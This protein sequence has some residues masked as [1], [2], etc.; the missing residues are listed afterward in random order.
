MK[1]WKR[2][3]DLYILTEHT[4]RARAQD[5]NI[6]L[7][8]FLSNHDIFFLGKNTVILLFLEFPEVSAYLTAADVLA[9]SSLMIMLK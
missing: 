6:W 9:G 3:L 5:F 7:C 8:L 2:D 1:P 4:V